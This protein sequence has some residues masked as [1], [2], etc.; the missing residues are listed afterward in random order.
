MPPVPPAATFRCRIA[1]FECLFVCLLFVL[2]FIFA[3]RAKVTLFA[4]MLMRAFFR[5]SS[6]SRIYQ[7]SN[8]GSLARNISDRVKGTSHQ[9]C[10]ILSAALPTRYYSSM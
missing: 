9:F 4:K 3:E 1:V 5:I 6:Q 7:L 2:W 10:P 8:S